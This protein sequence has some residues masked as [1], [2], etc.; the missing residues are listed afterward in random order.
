ME[1]PATDPPAAPPLRLRPTYTAIECKGCT[2]VFYPLRHD[3][4]FHS[5]ACKRR[6]W[7]HARMRAATVYELMYDWRK[8]RGQGEGKGKLSEIARLI[9][10]WIIA[11]REAGVKR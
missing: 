5:T 1:Q 4:V 7:S 2:T 3:Q 10:E 8:N 11:D 6:W 9:D